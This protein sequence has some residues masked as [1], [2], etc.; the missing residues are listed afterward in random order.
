MVSRTSE[1]VDVIAPVEL[2]GRQV[3]WTRVGLGQRS[4][5]AQLART[6][7]NGVIY[8]LFAIGVGAV[9]AA[10]M[11]TSLTA[12]LYRIRSVSAAIRA[13]RRDAR[14][15]DLGTDEVGTLGS[16]FNAMLNDLAAREAEIRLQSAALEAAANAIVITDRESRILWVNSAFA[17]LSGYPRSEC[18]GNAL[19]DL[20]RSGKQSDA[21]YQQMWQ[22]ILDGR[23]WTG[24]LVNR[25]KDGSHYPEEM[26]I[27]PLRD[28]KGE[29]THFIAVKQDITA[30]RS[31]E[32]AL[33][34]SEERFREM[35]ETITQVF[36]IADAERTKMLYISPS[37]E[38]IWGRPREALYHSVDAWMEAI[39]P[40]DRKRLTNIAERQRKGDYDETY[41][42]V[43]PDGAERWIHSR[44]F[45]VR[46]ANGQ[47]GHII[48]VAEDVTEAKRLEEQFLRAQRLEAVGTLASGIAHDLNNILSPMFLVTGLLRSSL[49][50]PKDLE[51]LRMI[52]TSAQ[53]GAG[54]V[55]QL[56]TFSRG[57]PGERMAVQPQH[58]V[59]EMCHIMS[60][61][62]PRNIE[63]VPEIGAGLWSVRADPTQ[64]HQVLMNL[65]VNARDA[66]PN[67]GRLTIGARN[68][69][70]VDAVPHDPPLKAGQYVVLSVRDTG[71][72]IPD[73]IKHRIFDPFFTTKEFGKGTGLGLSTVLGIVKGHGGAVGV[74]SAVGKGTGFRIFLPA[75]TAAE[76]ATDAGSAT[77]PARG[78]GQLIL[79]VDDE[80]QIRETL[81]GLL[82]RN[83]Y[84]VITASNGQDAI[85]KINPRIGGLKVVI[86]DLMMPTMDG[87]ALL[88]VLGKHAPQVKVIATS[89]LGGSA[90]QEEL[91]ELGVEN[92]L[93]KPFEPEDLLRLLER[94]L[95]E[96]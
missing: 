57:S 46:D 3:G 67:G 80:Q 36:W 44:A 55:R 39:H 43:R 23:I 50:D 78:K 17:T 34:E 96:R 10:F 86:T 81:E 87:V 47:V 71:V 60:E 82:E 4:A 45:P 61:T 51:Y 33:R 53:R 72:G 54:V 73:D 88:R 6:V 2:A 9:I 59:K 94:V 89:R 14:V 75:E 68:E 7:R 62:F 93:P 19:G 5:S 48:G 20:V 12:R 31:G 38:K 24:E 74:E 49:R 64:L 70:V 18:F 26:T 21:F 22:T 95:A 35:V 76:P 1:L 58:L 29:I 37:Y 63:I 40:D 77:A 41:R 27:A 28:G 79:V 30:R 92:V 90:R 52:E 83:G 42:I 85:A 8:A 13:G 15:P 56:L 16:D 66:M 11:G 91:R 69:T 25:R 84:R 32:K 65:C